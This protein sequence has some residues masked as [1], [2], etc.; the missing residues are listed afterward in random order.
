[1]GRSL[2]M[3]RQIYMLIFYF[4]AMGFELLVSSEENQVAVRNAKFLKS[5]IKRLEEADYFKVRIYFCLDFVVV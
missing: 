4:Q 5:Y 2:T 3:F 1:M